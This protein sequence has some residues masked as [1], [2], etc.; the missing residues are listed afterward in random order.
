LKL[1][2]SIRLRFPPV[3]KIDTEGNIVKQYESI[4]DVMLDGYRPDLVKK[5]LRGDNKLHGGYYWK[6]I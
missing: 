6:Y 4:T 1:K 3:N 5:V 2:E